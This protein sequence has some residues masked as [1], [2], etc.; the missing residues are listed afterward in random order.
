MERELLT[1]ASTGWRALS[2]R[3]TLALKCITEGSSEGT[4]PTLVK[5]SDGAIPTK[6]LFSVSEDLLFE[7]HSPQRRFKWERQQIDQLWQDIIG[8]HESNRDSYFL[9]TLL[10]VRLDKNRR[11]SVIDGQQRITTLSI[12]L[13]V[14]RDHCKEFEGLEGRVDVIQRL[15]SRLDNAGKPVGSLVVTLQDRDNQ[16]YTDLVREPGSTKRVPSQDGLVSEAVDR[17]TQLVKEYISEK[18]DE[19]NSVDCLSRLCDYILDRIMFLPLEVRSEAEGYLVFDT[20]NTRGLTP[21]RW[22]ALKARLA[23]VARADPD[24]SDEL[25]TTWNTADVRLENAGQGINAMGDYIH[26][27]WSSRVGLHSKKDIRQDCA[28][29][30]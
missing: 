6:K 30:C 29:A 25:M 1:A 3:K 24:L 26:A 11:V 9:G 21:S 13:A 23:T 16:V 14:L 17:L 28:T 15:I 12:L 20:T 10:L 4:M 5:I 7:I 27:V 18:D 8:A 22:E 2:K 19:A